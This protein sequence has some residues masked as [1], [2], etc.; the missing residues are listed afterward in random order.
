MSRCMT[1]SWDG[2]RSRFEYNHTLVSSPPT[3]D[4]STGSRQL[5]RYSK[6]AVPVV[7][8]AETYLAVPIYGWNAGS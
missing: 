3:G 8:G 6:T 7:V 1:T 5:F 2:M 4:G